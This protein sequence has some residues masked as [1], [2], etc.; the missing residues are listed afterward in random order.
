[1]HRIMAHMVPYYPDLERSLAVAAGLIDG[2]ASYLEIQFPFSDPTADG[3][4][5]QAAC[6]AAL[7]TGFT[8]DRGLAF[9]EEVASMVSRSERQVPLFIMS[10]ASPV[11]VRGPREFL[12]GGVAAG[13]SGFILPD[14]PIDCDEGVYSIGRE[15]RTYVMPVMVT[16]AKQ[17]RI[18]LLRKLAPEYV[19]VALRKGIT[20]RR[21]EIA[22][23]N[24]A[25][26]EKLAPL[27]MK[28][29]AGFGISER[30]QVEALTPHVYGV[31]VGTALVKTVAEHAEDSPSDLRSALVSAMFSLG[32]QG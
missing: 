16:S 27:G 28:I 30:S 14:L 4:V 26:L 10:Y 6:H 5:I 12:S 20:G 23:E 31:I 25:F 19:Y 21:T 8:I 1:M 2:G 9:V 32:A 11:V 17:E 18:D 15:L 22:A 7:E 3:P 24:L 13:A 29:M